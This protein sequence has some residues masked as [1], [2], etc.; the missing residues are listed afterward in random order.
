MD[1]TRQE[2]SDKV[3]EKSYEPE[4]YNRTDELSKGM[5]ITH[6]QVS[7][8]FTEGTVDGK[9]DDVEEDG[10]LKSHNGE[11]IPREGYEYKKYDQKTTEKS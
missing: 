9:I 10:S 6:E 2:N 5:T 1:K 7:D 4:D 3:A 11:A 8:T